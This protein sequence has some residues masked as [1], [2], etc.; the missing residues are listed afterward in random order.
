MPSPC[1]GFANVSADIGCSDDMTV[2]TREKGEES[3]EEEMGIWSRKVSE[4]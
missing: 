1:L 3:E 4:E 2:M